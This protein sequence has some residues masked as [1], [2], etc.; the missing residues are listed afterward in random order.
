M[1]NFNPQDP[2]LF[3]KASDNS[4]LK[5]GPTTVSLFAPNSNPSGFLGNSIGEMW[6]DTQID[7]S[8]DRPREILKIWNGTEWRPAGGAIMQ[9]ELPQ[10]RNT[11]L[12]G[13]KTGSAALPTF[14]PLED[15]DMPD[16]I[17]PGKISGGDTFG[18]LLIGGTGSWASGY[19]TSS[20]DSI[21]IINK[22]H[23]IDVDVTAGNIAGNGS[24][25]NDYKTGDGYVQLNYNGKFTGD[26][27]FKFFKDTGTLRAHGPTEL[28]QDPLTHFHIIKGD[29]TI[30]GDV[31]LTDVYGMA[32]GGDLAVGHDVELGTTADDSLVVYSTSFFNSDVS[33][34]AGSD[35]LITGQLTVNQDTTLGTGTTNNHTVNAIST[36]NGPMTMGRSCGDALLFKGAGQFEC[37]LLLDED[38]T[39][40]GD[41][42]LN[43]NV[44]MGSSCANSITVKGTQYN[45][46]D[47]LIGTGVP[48]A[49][50]ELIKFDA[51][52]GLGKFKNHIEVDK[53]ASVGHLGG[54]NYGVVIDDA[55]NIDATDTITAAFFVGDGRNLTNLALPNT[56]L[57]HGEI[58]ATIGPPPSNP[59]E[60]DFYINNKDGNVVAGWP[61]IGGQTIANN[62]FIYYATTG[63]FLGS[64]QD[65][66][67]FVTVGTTQSIHGVKTFL[68]EQYFKDTVEIDGAVDMHSTLRVDGNTSIGGTLTVADGKK[69]TL[70]GQLQVKQAAT[71]DSSLLVRG[72]TT[73]GTT[74]TDTL[75][76]NAES[77]F[78]CN[79]TIGSAPC[80]GAFNVWSPTTLHCPTTIDST[81]NVTGNVTL[82]SN[83]G[84]NT[85][86]IRGVTTINCATSLKSTLTVDGNTQLKGTLV[87]TGTTTL[88]NHLTVADG[89]NTTL[90]QH[91]T[92]KGNET[93]NGTSLIKGKTT[94]FASKNC[95]SDALLVNGKSVFEC[96]VTMNAGL[97][98]SAGAVNIA[99]NVTLGTTC[100]N[101]LTINSTTT[102]KCATTI[103][104]TLTVSGNHATAL[105]GTL[106]VSGNTQINGTFT[107]A[108]NK[109]SKLG[110]NTEVNGNVYPRTTGNR[111]IG[112]GSLEFN[113]VFAKTYKGIAAT[114]FTAGGNNTA[115]F[116]GGGTGATVLGNQG[117]GTTQ[118]RTSV[119]SG[120]RFYKE[121]GTANYGAFNFQSL[122]A[123]RTYTWQNKNGTVA[124]TS[125]L[126]TYTHLCIQTGGNNANPSIR[127]GGQGASAGI[128]QDIT[129]EGINGVVSTRINNSKLQLKAK[130]ANNT[131]GINGD[132]IYVQLNNVDT[133]YQH[134]CQQVSGSNNN[135]NISLIAGSRGSGT[136]AI[137]LTGST[138]ASVVRT[139]NTGL[140]I[141]GT[142]YT[143]T[144][145]QT[146]GNNTNPAIRMTAS[147]ATSGNQD[148]TFTGG[149]GVNISRNSNTQLT[150]SAQINGN[151]INNGSSGISVNLGAV[152]TVTTGSCVT[153]GGNNTNPAIRFA[154]TGRATGN[155][156]ITHTGTNG[157]TI[158]RNSNTQMTFAAK[159]A[160]STIGIN[161][162]GIYVNTGNLGINNGQINVNAG[163]GLTASG[164][165]ATANQSGNTTRTLSAKAG[166][167]TIGVNSSGIYVNTGNVDTVTTG[168]VA[169]NSG[170]DTNPYLR[171]QRSGRSTGADNIMFQGGGGTTVKRSGGGKVIISSTVPAAV[172]TYWK[173]GGGGI[174]PKAGNQH[175]VPNGNANLGTTS[176]RWSN[177]YTKDLH[178]S[179]EGQ[180][181]GNDVDGSWGDW[182]IQE[183]EDA[184][185]VINNR[186]GQK[187]K[188][189]LTPV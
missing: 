145:I 151:T 101:T 68:P 169:Q 46:C 130:A 135:P 173:S 154:K 53:T 28:G 180:E 96:L 77:Q 21:T 58:D 129:I 30:S 47:V 122:A 99:G 165:N 64:I 113:N 49:D 107:V 93:V 97:T 43:G 40:N 104:N 80:S 36:F 61:N 166:N 12:A 32:I 156:D 103:T 179:N 66:Q 56:M 181:G 95:S 52:T 170:S 176:N 5:I 60:G 10:L 6:Y 63:W 50:A 106:T 79:F 133:T 186:S 85:V 8:I 139:G 148:I 159:A 102:I 144:C 42:F 100:S 38:L 184:L 189:N 172:T 127:L 157:I 88:N 120:F 2:G 41:S 128:N 62:Q 149:N 164:A 155:T 138:G 17:S 141:T 84:G 83:C 115:S 89:K 178:L 109:L 44:E 146:G 167:S 131:I 152:D 90:G 161:S 74:C 98:V 26:S 174:Q 48:A 118:L 182:T 35:M 185:Y 81:L 142:R 15:E 137:R 94:L 177:V 69:T 23:A 31:E 72:S 132:G 121:G 125:D 92:V 11:V 1:L 153:T 171:F 175:V 187:F 110:G 9:E 14:R 22:D 108:N 37:D 34:L 67:G 112:T 116:R 158:T 27:R 45:K 55:G 73:L 25:G 13:P 134:I 24:P 168:T 136:Q 78:N 147:G 124:L 82:G 183:G 123:N 4:L 59:L 91:L 150:F 75:T 119:V 162:S 54:G 18:E 19:L 143:Q 39:V 33:L 29:T 16:D 188:M 117:A 7:N 111:D 71:L 140:T 70:G 51:A 163:N 126:T 76:V 105:G 87:V 114:T 65:T 86:L 20:D 3:F 57:F 160:N